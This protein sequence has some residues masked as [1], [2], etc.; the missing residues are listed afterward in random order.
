MAERLPR[1]F[2]S[3]P[4]MVG[5]T[6]VLDDTVSR[7][8]GQVLRLRPG[9]NLIL[10]DGSG[11]EYRGSITGVKPRLAAAVGEFF[12]VDR[13][14]PLFTRLVQGISRGERMDYTLQ[15]AVELGVSEI[16]PVFTRRT[17]VRLDA[18]KE[19]KRLERWCQIVRS[20]CEQSGRTAVPT[21][22]PPQQLTQW[23]ET[24]GKGAR[25]L[26]DPHAD[27]P[28]LGADVGTEATLLI[29]PE[30][31]LDNAERELAAAQGFT[32]A[33]LGPRVLRTETAAVAALAILQATAGDVGASG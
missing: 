31:G 16:V 6:V 4:L 9:E 32:G 29:G 14:S 24:P 17:V 18:A 12:D 21:V 30:G 7:H 8:A 2:V 15:K 19:T 25:L 33:R 11:G 13:E 28:L 23:L 26:L 1:F 3:Q 20:A 22:R 10:F 5:Q 27:Q